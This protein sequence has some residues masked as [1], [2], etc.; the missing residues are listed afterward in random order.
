MVD[1]CPYCSF[2]P[3]TTNDFCSKHKPKPFRT[4]QELWDEIETLTEQ[5]QQAKVREAGLQ[6]KIDALMLEY[7]T[8]EMTEE[9]ITNWGKHQKP[10]DTQGK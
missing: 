9:Q 10:S 1:K 2:N 6:A 8:D 7:C 3:T 5:L 4:K